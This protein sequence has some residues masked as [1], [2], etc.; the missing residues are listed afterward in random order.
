M[1]NQADKSQ[2][3][4]PHKLDEARKKGQVAKSNEFVSM[5]SLAAMLAALM[6]VLPALASSI[7]IN[8]SH[9]LK[10]ANVLVQSD[11]MIGAFLTHFFKDILGTVGLVMGVG[12]AITIIANLVHAGPVFS[13]HPLKMDLSKLN[14]VNGIKKI[15]SRKALVEVF[16]LVLKLTCFA[17]AC[18]FIWKQLCRSL[19]FTHQLNAYAVLTEWKSAVILVV[20]TF[21]A[22]FILFA[23][24]D[25]WYSKR[26]FAKKMRMSTR[27]IKDEYKRREGDPEIKHKRKKGMQTLMRNVMG[28]SQLKNA[29]VVI[30]NPTH[31]AVALQYRPETMALPKVLVKGKGFLAKMIIRR[32]YLL[33][34]PVMRIP[35]LTRAIYK[36]CEINSPIPLE[37]QVPVARVYRLLIKLPG[38]KVFSHA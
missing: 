33:R 4:T 30:T 2:E 25:L 15:F 20:V 9:W 31:Y 37:Q 13:L 26:E 17:A 38:N 27:D 28:L 29:D 24:F 11:G 14:P 16:K 1:D 18:W 12:A 5:V 34:L 21:L 7:A 6:I 19:L 35:E 36:D 3:A 32:A 8:T 22:V 23:I 10:N